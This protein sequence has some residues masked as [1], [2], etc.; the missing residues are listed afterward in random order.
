MNIDGTCAT[1]AFTLICCRCLKNKSIGLAIG[2]LQRN[3]TIHFD[4]PI[5]VNDPPARIHGCTFII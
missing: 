3:R 5:T 2:R 4:Q 1:V